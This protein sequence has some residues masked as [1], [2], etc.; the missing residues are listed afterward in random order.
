MNI[1]D[2]DLNLLRYFLMVMEEGTISR[3]AQRL[4]LTQ[5]ALSRAMAR[6][7]TAIGDPLFI[8][9]AKGM[10]PTARALSLFAPIQVAVGQLDQALRTAIHFDPQESK[11]RFRLMATDYVEWLL[12]PDLI[13]QSQ[14]EA[15]HISFDLIPTEGD[16]FARLESGEAD[17]LIGQFSQL[18]GSLKS[19]RLWQD[20]YICLAHRDN[21]AIHQW[22]LQ[23]F[24]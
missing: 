17:L 16:F 3:A 21:P 9:T 22:N 1:N 12:M 11:R 4:G 10:R 6:L 23:S 2:L 8:R 14:K 24:A 7:R 19:T 15:P 20:E 18:P 5:P 13:E